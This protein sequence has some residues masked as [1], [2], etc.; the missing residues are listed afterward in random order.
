MSAAPPLFQRRINIINAPFLVKPEGVP[1][2]ISPVGEPV[3]DTSLLISTGQAQRFAGHALHVVDISVEHVR[4]EETRRVA[5]F[6]SGCGTSGIIPERIN[7]RPAHSHK[8]EPSRPFFPGRLWC[9]AAPSQQHRHSS[10]NSEKTLRT[11]RDALT[12]RKPLLSPNDLGI[13]DILRTKV[14][15]IAPL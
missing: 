10:K 12:G 14:C 2:F 9:R 13:K 11:G 4:L 8:R 3:H 1:T 5:G 6:I 15:I 7:H